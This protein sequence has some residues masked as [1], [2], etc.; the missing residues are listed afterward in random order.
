MT[1]A[2]D[3]ER[4]E[5]LSSALLSA[6]EGCAVVARSFPANSTFSVEAGYYSASK[7]GVAFGDHIKAVMGHD[8]TLLTQA[9]NIFAGTDSAVADDV[10]ASLQR[11]IAPPREEWAKKPPSGNQVR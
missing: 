8:A 4:V 1:I 5:G 3:T 7:D 2:S 9:A 10:L 11:C 6:S